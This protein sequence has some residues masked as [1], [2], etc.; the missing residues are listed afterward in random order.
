[1]WHRT[2]EQLPDSV[3]VAL[4]VELGLLSPHAATVTRASS[5]T[6]RGV[7]GTTEP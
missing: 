3:V 4:A 5:S 1:M 7:F 6:R 2:L